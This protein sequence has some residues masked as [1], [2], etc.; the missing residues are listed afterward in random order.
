VIID[1]DEK[2]KQLTIRDTSSLCLKLEG[3]DFTACEADI[4]D[5]LTIEVS[6]GKLQLKAGD[7]DNGIQA[8]HLKTTAKAFCDDETL[9]IDETNG[10]QVKT[11]A[12]GQSA[13]ASGTNDI[14]TSSGSY[15]NMGSGADAMNIVM[16]TS[17]GP[18][19]LN[20]TATLR[21]EDD[22]AQAGVRLVADEI[23]RQATMWTGAGTG[24]DETFQDPYKGAHNACVALGALVTLDAGEH[25]FKV[26]WRKF[27]TGTIYQK[28]AT[29]KRILTAVEL[30]HA[31][32]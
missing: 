32:S 22:K 1:E 21:T 5:A 27:G 7:A 4:V 12:F 23:S 26:Q 13:Q 16:T 6:G 31:V 29:Y 20:F 25:T 14:S 28:G 30:P 8:G 15:V 24:L 11:G 9:E 2:I 19:L 3:K 17:G 18:V 10:L